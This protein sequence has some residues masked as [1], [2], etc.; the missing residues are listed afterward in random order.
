MNTYI[1]WCNENEG[2]A[3]PLQEIAS[4]LSDSGALLPDDIVLDLGILVPPGLSGVRFSCITVSPALF[5]VAIA[6]D[7]GILL[8]GTFL[9]S[10]TQPYLAY[11]LVPLVQN[12]GGWVV[13]GPHVGTTMESYRFSTPGQGGIELRAIRTVQPPGVSGFQRSGAGAGIL[14]TGLVQLKVQGGLIAERDPY[15]PQNIILRLDPA[16]QAQYAL[17]CSQSASSSTCPVPV[18]RSINNV[19]ADP[20]G[21]ITLRFE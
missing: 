4:R 11:P 14:A 17:P 6:S 20:H 13:F 16:Y 15:D 5:S 12:T 2:R 7:Q 19:P 21:N 1:Q 9:R 18:V 3:Y 10:E 8:A